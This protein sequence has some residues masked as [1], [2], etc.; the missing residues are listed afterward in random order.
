MIT[1][2]EVM[3]GLTLHHQDQVPTSPDRSTGPQFVWRVTFLRITLLI[4][5]G[6]AT[7]VTLEPFDY[8]RRLCFSMVDLPLEAHL[9]LQC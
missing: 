3:A 6:T 1:K 9:Y 8:A 5:E 7:F 2:F 4:K